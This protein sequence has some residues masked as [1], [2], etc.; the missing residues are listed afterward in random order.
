MAPSRRTLLLGAGGMAALAACS[1]DDNG[2]PASTN[3]APADFNVVPR[4]PNAP[5]FTP[6]EVRLPV[7][8]SDGQNLVTTGPATINGRIETADGT[9]VVDV[10][11]TFRGDGI[12]VPYYEVR[13]QLTDPELYTLRLDGDDGAG[14]AFQVFDAEQ[15]LSPVSGTKLPPFDTPTVDDHRGVEPY[16]SLTPDPCPLHDVT[17]RAALTSGKKVCYLVGTPAHCQTGTCAPGLEFLVAEHD[18]VGADVVMVHADVYADD[19]ATT[20]APA[21][22]ALQIDYEPILYF[23]DS[24]GVI[25]DRLDGVWDRTELRARMDLFLKR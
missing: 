17:L 20:I 4:F 24:T 3:G 5:L 19:K 10:V 7:S 2:A 14:A 21:I 25:V 13:A 15:I 18:R 8:L 22:D 9:K 12:T 23:C 16:C 6:G 1:S 11:A